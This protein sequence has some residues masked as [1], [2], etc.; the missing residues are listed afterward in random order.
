MGRTAEELQ[1]RIRELQ[2]SEPA[3]IQAK[4]T[5][6]DEEE[7]TCKVD[8]DNDLIIEDVRLRSIIDKEKKGFC[9]IPAIDSIVLISRI[10]GANEFFVSMFSEIDKII[11]TYTEDMEITFDTE[12]IFLRIKERS[13]EITEEAI[14]FNAGDKGSFATDIN[15]LVDK[16]SSIEGEI[17]SL[18]QVFT[19]WIPA[20]MDGGAVLKGAV[21]SWASQPIQPVTTVDSIKDEL[22][23]H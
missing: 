18:K 3:T 8:L 2:G 11:F 15:K 9:F 14:T 22:I 23:K 19:T 20:P 5:E 13:I 21:T 1:R 16:I 4:V 10:R 6:V 17:N 12:K 7:F